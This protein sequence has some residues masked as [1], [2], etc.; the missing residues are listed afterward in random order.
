VLCNTNCLY[1]LDRQN[2]RRAQM[3]AI[4]ITSPIRAFELLRISTPW[5]VRGRYRSSADSEA[6]KIETLTDSSSQG[7]LASARTQPLP[8]LFFHT[9]HA[10]NLFPV[11]P[12]IG[13]AVGLLDD[14]GPLS[15]R[16][17]DAHPQGD[18]E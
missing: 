9:L 18:L 11:E 14:V 6:K 12:S 2:A 5:G 1:E 4:L 15:L 16:G 10:F 7:K 13:G 17:E 3:S 8:R